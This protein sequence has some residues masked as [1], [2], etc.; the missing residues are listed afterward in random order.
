MSFPLPPEFVR[1][2]LD[3]VASGQYASPN[4]VLAAALRA[5][6]HAEVELDTLRREVQAGIDQVERGQV[7]DGEEAIAWLKGRIGRRVRR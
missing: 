4:D 5:L 7:V 3:R 1:A 6:E 2:V